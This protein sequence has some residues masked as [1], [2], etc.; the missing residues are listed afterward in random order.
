VN[1]TRRKYFGYVAG[2]ALML[3]L[4]IQLIPYGKNHQN[5]P[6]LQEPP[7]NVPETRELAKRACFDCHS[8]DTI[9]PWYSNIAPVSWLVQWDVDKGRNHLNF[10]D[11]SQFEEE[12]DH[13]GE[14]VLEGEMPPGQYRFIH[15]EAQLSENES[16]QLAHGLKITLAG[17]TGSHED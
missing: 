17:F 13:V 8:N 4:L 16:V 3:A 10:S 5:P 9:W 6:V 14:S 1:K 12:G 15:P 2:A 7:W 11:I